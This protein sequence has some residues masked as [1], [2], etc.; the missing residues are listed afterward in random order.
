MIPPAELLEARTV[1]ILWWKCQYCNTDY[2]CC[3]SSR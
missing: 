3:K 2:G 1:L